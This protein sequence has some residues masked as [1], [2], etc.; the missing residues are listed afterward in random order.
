VKRHIARQ[1][2]IGQL[3]DTMAWW[4]GHQR[5]AGLSDSEIFKLFFMRYG[6]DW[7]SAQK[8]KRDDALSLMEKL[9]WKG[10]V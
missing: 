6:I 2:T 5:A 7:L 4:A 3:R 1:E 10:K 8:M 9:T